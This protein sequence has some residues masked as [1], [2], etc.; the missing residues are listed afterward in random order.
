MTIKEELGMMSLILAVLINDE[1]TVNTIDDDL[2]HIIRDRAS[3]N[4]L[5]EDELIKIGD[6]LENHLIILTETSRT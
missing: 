4:E 5:S 1:Q 2:K 3:I 6:V